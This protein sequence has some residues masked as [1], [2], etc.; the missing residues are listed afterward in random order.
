MSRLI[1]N[2]DIMAAFLNLAKLAMI[3]AVLPI[4][5]AVVELFQQHEVV[6]NQT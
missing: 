2:S 5:T 3:L 1:A 6:K 4:T